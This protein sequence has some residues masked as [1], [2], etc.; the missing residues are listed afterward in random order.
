MFA[1]HSDQ[2]DIEHDLGT[3]QLDSKK[4]ADQAEE[5]NVFTLTLPMSSSFQPNETGD[6]NP[7]QHSDEEAQFDGVEAHKPQLVVKTHVRDATIEGWQKHFSAPPSLKAQ[8]GE[9][10]DI[11]ALAQK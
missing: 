7:D 3:A 10:I 4:L 6:K 1:A 8:H 11:T 9:V 5:H 2:L